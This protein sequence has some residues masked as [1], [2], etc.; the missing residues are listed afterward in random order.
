M[1]RKKGYFIF[2]NIWIKKLNTL[3]LAIIKSNKPRNVN[4]TPMAGPLTSAIKGLLK[5][6]KEH[7]YFLK[8]KY[9]KYLRRCSL[10]GK[11][12]SS[13]ALEVRVLCLVKLLKV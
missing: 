5:F 7:I 11:K 1:P 2:L 9:L 3:S 10:V 4:E 6:A 12:I 13:W 8:L